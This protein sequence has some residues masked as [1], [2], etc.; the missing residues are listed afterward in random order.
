VTER[1]RG[2][3][4]ITVGATHPALPELIDP[5]PQPG[6]VLAWGPSELMAHDRAP[7][8]APLVVGRSSSCEWCVDDHM[9]S[10]RHFAVDV[11]EPERHV[12][13]DLGSRNGVFVGGERV[14]GEVEI[15]PGAVVRA[16]GCIFVAVDDLGRLAPPDEPDTGGDMGG[17]FHTWAV[18]RTLRV[19]ARSGQPVLLEGES[20]VGKELAALELHRLSLELGRR[21]SLQLHNAACFAGEDDAVGS[22][23][24]VSRGAFTGVEARTG[25]LE[26]A[27]AGTLFLDEVHALPLR[28]QR[29]L[30]RFV[31]DGLLEALGQSVPGARR[32]LDVRLVFGTNIDVEEACEKGWLAHDLVARLLRVAVPPLR[33]RRADV[34][35]L[36]LTV[37]RRT[38]APEIAEAIVRELRV[39]AVERLCLHDYRQGNVRELVR[40]AVVAA[41]RISEG[42]SPAEALRGVL[43]DTLGEQR[44]ASSVPS[45]PAA[46]RP[47]Q[48]QPGPEGTS[49]YDRHRPE[50]LAVY[51]E[52]G[53]NLSRME[54]MLKERGVP[55]TRRWLAHFLDRW[56]VRPIPKR[57]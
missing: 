40:L 52:V 33:D 23:F 21:G 34:P 50:I 56:G 14:I 32:R 13:R 42:E 45:M 29:S 53:G 47:P 49:S 43:R 9:L 6:L 12:L 26:T 1:Q 25:A 41:A 46:P 16:G 35:S 37:L 57:G 54:A 2:S 18:R 39:E 44:S 5:G 20:G 22:L 38:V 51:A 24:G 17:R 48:P 36:F 28:V 3:I 15:L 19:A 7:L 8:G 27:D 10:R 11:A 31:E 30:L 55:C 4:D